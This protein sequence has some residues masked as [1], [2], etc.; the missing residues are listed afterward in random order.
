MLFQHLQSTN[1]LQISNNQS[2]MNY[3]CL[4]RARCLEHQPVVTLNLLFEMLPLHLR[5]GHAAYLCW[6][7]PNAGQ[8]KPQAVAWRR[9]GT[10]L[11]G[12]LGKMSRSRQG[13]ALEAPSEGIA[14]GWLVPFVCLILGLVGRPSWM[15][16]GRRQQTWPFTLAWIKYTE[17]GLLIC[18]IHVYA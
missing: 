10:R 11:F 4:L 9:W 13:R 6:L 5:V 17:F 2:K 1:Q 3:Y 15:V 14:P 7:Y 8:I 16:D 12:Q 18:I